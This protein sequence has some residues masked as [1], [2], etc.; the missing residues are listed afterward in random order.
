MKIL[1]CKIMG[2]V[3]NSKCYE[4]FTNHLNAESHPSR[5][6]C[7]KINVIEEVS[8]SPQTEQSA[9]ALETAGG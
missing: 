1:Q 9:L 5:V 4:C 3:D 8:V 7:K 2:E 6:L